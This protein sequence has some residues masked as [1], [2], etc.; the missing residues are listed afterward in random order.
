MTRHISANTLDDPI[1]SL[2]LD[3]LIYRHLQ[4]SNRQTQ[5]HQ[6]ETNPKTPKRDTPKDTKERHTQRHERE[7]NPKTPKR[8]SLSSIR[9]TIGS[10]FAEMCRVIKCVCP[11][12]HTRYAHVCTHIYIYMRAHAH[13]C[14]QARVCVRAHTHTHTCRMNVH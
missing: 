7:T 2:I 11:H 4:R 6:R 12:S 13:T 3:L 8:D 10:V 14:T 1:V 9:D 5:R